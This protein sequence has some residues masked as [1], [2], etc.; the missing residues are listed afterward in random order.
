LSNR[1][2][3]QYQITG[4]ASGYE[5]NSDNF[6]FDEASWYSN[7]DNT[8]DKDVLGAM[9]LKYSYRLGTLPS[10]L[11]VG[12]KTHIRTKDRAYDRWDYGWEGDDDLLLTPFVGDKDV[13]ILDGAYRIGPV[14]DGDK[15]RKEFVA[16]KDKLFE[17]EVNREDTDAEN[18]TADEKLYAYYAMNTLN[19]GNLMLLAG[20]RH[21]FTSLS[22]TS[23]K[24]EFNADGDYVSTTPEKGSLNYNNILPMTHLRYRLT[25]MTNVRAAVT[26]G[27]AR[28]NYRDLVPYLVVLPEDEELSKGNPDLKPTTA[29]NFDLMAEHYFQGIGIVSG[30]VFYKKLKNII[31]PY[32]ID[33]EGGPYDGYEQTQPVNGGSSELLGYEF[34]WQ[35]QLTFLPGVLSGLGIYAN[36]THTKSEADLGGRL[37]RSVL[38]GQSS[39]IANFAISYEKYGFSGRFSVNYHGKFIE[40]VGKDAEHDRIYK[41]H[42]Q[43]DFSASQRIFEGFRV[44]VEVLNLNKEPM[45][46]YMG[47]PSRPIQREFYSWWMHGGIKFDM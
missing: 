17:G 34:N 41:E 3:P 2:T 43:M 32:T 19:A 1:N 9:N 4:L 23:N 28:P 27:I 22:N 20:F 39:D 18:Y 46:Y 8:N 12:G 6:T 24:V 30:G 36:Y 37:E 33:L 10:E 29:T 38:P 45:L 21:E 42:L 40:E 26:T 5:M 11:K 7:K 14:I 47:K 31:Y 13:S 44:Y 15:F 35:Q 25:P 16:Q